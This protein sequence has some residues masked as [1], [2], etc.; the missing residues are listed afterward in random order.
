MTHFLHRLAPALALSLPLL[1]GAQGVAEPR[2]TKAGTPLR[3]PSAFADYKPYSDADLGNWRALNDAVGAAALK[4]GGHAGH[5]ASVTPSAASA[6]AP[7][8]AA[9]A[10]QPVRQTPPMHH[11]HHGGPK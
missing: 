2:N 1:A 5:G 4:Q 3:Y 6:P 10:A 9:S 11:S 7:A 8:A